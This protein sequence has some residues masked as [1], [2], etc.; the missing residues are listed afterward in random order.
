M[1]AFQYGKSPWH[2]APKVDHG[3]GKI[4]TRV[5]AAKCGSSNFFGNFSVITSLGSSV[6]LGIAHSSHRAWDKDAKV[7]LGSVTL[8]EVP[9]ECMI[10][11]HGLLFHFGGRAKWNSTIFEQNLRAFFYL[12]DENWQSSPIPETYLADEEGW[13]VDCV[14]CVK[15]QEK[16]KK[17]R[18]NGEDE[19]VWKSGK[20]DSE[21]SDL[22]P[23][24]HVM[25]DIGMLGWAVLKA[26]QPKVDNV[27]PFVLEKRKLITKF[28]KK[29]WYNIQPKGK[30]M[31]F[32]QLVR[33][34]FVR[35]SCF[36]F[37]LVLAT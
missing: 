18:C 22:S 17:E 25:G 16:L 12:H 21:I 29:K 35:S 2:D 4:L 5:Q 8:V 9:K 20:S 30:N 13:C 15:I 31:Q 11:F 6:T 19:M 32:P 1:D 28:S 34:N 26:F 36:Q 24:D 3:N 14:A 23:G 37:T 27:V 7:H 10:I 33:P